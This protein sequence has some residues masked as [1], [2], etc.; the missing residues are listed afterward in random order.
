MATP[1]SREGRD[2]YATP[3]GKIV[4]VEAGFDTSTAY[5]DLIPATKDDVDANAYE[6]SAASLQGPSL[7]DDSGEYSGDAVFGASTLSPEVQA[8]PLRDEVVEAAQDTEAAAVEQFVA[9]PP[10]EPEAP[11]PFSRNGRDYYVD[12]GTGKVASVDAGFDP[13]EEYPYL[14]PATAEQV[15]A[16]EI[17]KRSGNF[18]DQVE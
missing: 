7:R 3:D 9:L 8:L 18:I 10:A 17:Q 11:K 5:P 6:K 14:E 15:R 4:S 16:H 12:K 2:Y 1:F 13:S